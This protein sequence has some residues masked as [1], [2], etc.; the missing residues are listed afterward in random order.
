MIIPPKMGRSRAF[1]EVNTDANTRVEVNVDFNRKSVFEYSK[2]GNVY[3]FQGGFEIENGTKFDIGADW[4]RVQQDSVSALADLKY[5]TNSDTL[6][7]EVAEIPDS[8][9]TLMATSSLKFCGMT[10]IPATC[11]SN[12]I[13]TKAQLWQEDSESFTFTD[14]WSGEKVTGFNDANFDW[15]V[16]FIKTDGSGNNVSKFVFNRADG[17]VDTSTGANIADP[18]TYTNPMTAVKSKLKLITHGAVAQVAGD[19]STFNF[20]PTNY[21]LVSGSETRVAHHK[22]WCE[23]ANIGRNYQCWQF[24]GNRG[25]DC[26]CCCRYYCGIGRPFPNCGVLR[27]KEPIPRR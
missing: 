1:F 8:F 18:T 21:N 9:K 4:A 3:E 5:G 26:G 17:F 15:L 12:I 16:K 2:V 20:D 7:V 24:D 25:Y 23:L 14:F 13:A 10:V 19:T 6:P 22:L 27:Y 11:T